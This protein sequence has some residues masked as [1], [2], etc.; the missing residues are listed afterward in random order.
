MS[1][2]M[3][4]EL[5][6]RETEMAALVSMLDLVGER[7]GATVIRGEAGIGKSF[8]LNATKQHAD[9]RGMQTIATA[10]LES[11]ARLPLAG[12][13]TLLRPLLPRVA[14]LPAPQR[15][16][17]NVAFG[18]STGERPELF[19]I[20]L[21]TLSLLG[22]AAA[23]RPML[24]L[25]ED[26]QWLDEAT[27]NVLVFVAR[28]LGSDQVVMLA[29][30]RDGYATPFDAPDLSTL[31][32]DRLD[33]DSVRT[34]LA[35]KWPDLSSAVRERV[36]ATAAGS[37]LALAE[38]PKALSP[39]HLKDTDS[40]P[41][42]LPMTTQL[43]RAFLE[44]FEQLPDL[45]RSALLIAALNDS[46]SLAEALT[47]LSRSTGPVVSDPL[48][49]ALRHGLLRLDGDV[50]RFRHPLVRSAIAQAASPAE[51]QIAHIA[52]AEITETT[53]PQ[54]SIWHRAAAT[55]A[56]DEQI[57]ALL[58]SN[59]RDSI[60]R[61]G[62]AS[63]L[64]AFS[65]AA[66]LSTDPATRGSRW[67]RAAEL[68]YELGEAEPTARLL[69]LADN[70]PLGTH[71]RARLAW[72]REATS[73]DLGGGSGA[74]AATI[75]RALEIARNGDR[76]IAIRILRLCAWNAFNF[77]T[78]AASAPLFVAALEELGLPENDPGVLNILVS[79][80]PV[81]FGSHLMHH[82]AEHTREASLDPDGAF[83]LANALGALGSLPDAQLL[84]VRAAEQ[85]RKQ[86]MIRQLSLVLN[87]ASHSAFQEGRC[88]SAQAGAEESLQLAYEARMPPIWSGATYALQAKL[89][90]VRGEHALATELA[91]QASA[92]A[93]ELNSRC[94]GVLTQI[95]RGLNELTAGRFDRAYHELRRMFDPTDST[96]HSF[97]SMFALG[98]LAEA[99][100]ATGRQAEVRDLL[101]ATEPWTAA[102][103]TWL[104]VSFQ[105]ASYLMAAD[106]EAEAFYQAG[107]NAELGTW[108]FYRARLNLAHG[109]WLRRHRRRADSR[110]VLRLAL[111]SFDALGAEPWAAR[112]RQ[113]LR[114]AGETSQ[115]GPVSD[116]TLTAQELQVAQLAADGLS[117]REIGERLFLSPRTVGSHLYRIFPKLDIT[118]RNQLPRA[119]R[120][121]LS[122]HELGPTM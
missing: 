41:Q 76:N 67:L 31:E 56:P 42:T 106:E 4:T 54:R 55:F 119:L 69:N 84:L 15:D 77:D 87:L 7:G 97:W 43:E 109:I 89:A 19:L 49:P 70:T 46:D 116:D 48:L 102:E 24:A 53:E 22:E 11:E 103:S 73:P 32:V 23:E 2:T 115:S 25:I 58:E 33:E 111:E 107:L 72:L 90:G 61:G 96:Y 68:A 5:F 92:T 12:L 1:A 108:P 95:A 120:L 112:V 63:A 78:L 47:A 39:H 91:D 20:A 59:A 44:R 16:A 105:Y 71:D 110:P 9:A 36:I 79:V 98:E 3:P 28:R 13:H 34:L 83:D 50:L 17:L 8:L 10:G 118:S 66:D 38:L 117:N 27:A 40:L 101:K 100:L 82:A 60:E 104:R 121:T 75:E 64:A 74:I 21:A 81:R 62:L 18:L 122:E 45:T 37:P 29:A 51:R 14:H 113:E 52:L 57:A 93:V 114:A 30:L 65:R 88:R 80:D 85:L 99:A 6:G 26:V 94:L 86:G 35:A